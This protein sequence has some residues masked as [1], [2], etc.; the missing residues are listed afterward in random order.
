MQVRFLALLSGSGIWHCCELWYRSQTR[1]RSYVAVAAA[2]P[3]QPLAW[4][5]PYAALK[6]KEGR[7]K[8]RIAEFL[9]SDNQSTGQ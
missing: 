5:L 1:L 7:E 2:A 9:H 6:R 8:G 3:V 4:E